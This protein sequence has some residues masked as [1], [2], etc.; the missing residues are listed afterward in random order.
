[1]YN[2]PVDQDQM[3]LIYNVVIAALVSNFSGN[4]E[5]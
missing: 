5:A 2:E 3:C 4:K 1:M